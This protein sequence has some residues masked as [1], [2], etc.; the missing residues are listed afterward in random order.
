MIIVNHVTICLGM[1][2][3]QITFR[4][5]EYSDMSLFKEHRS[6]AYQWL[7]D[8]YDYEL[9]EY[10]EWFDENVTPF[11]YWIIVDGVEA[12]YFRTKHY[13]PGN[14]EAVI[15]MDLHPNFRG[16]KL[17]KPC[18][19]KF[20]LFLKSMGTELF[21]LY[22]LNTN[23]KAVALYERLKFKTIETIDGDPRGPIIKMQ[24]NYE[25]NP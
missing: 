14:K 3:K 17:A 24:L 4:R 13:K 22:V 1:Q 16:Q 15:G 19:I 6:H 7:T 11:Y 20:I 8:P 21:T 5:L 2:I 9:H 10:Q 25:T 12:G 23:E 18:Y